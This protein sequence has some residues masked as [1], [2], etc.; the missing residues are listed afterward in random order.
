MVQNMF[1]FIVYVNESIIQGENGAYFHSDAPLMFRN[2]RISTLYELKQVILSHH[3][4]NGPRE[5]RRLAYRFQ[6]VTPDDRLEYRPSWLS[7]DRHVWITF[8][9]HRRIMQDRFME[10]L[11]EVCHVDGPSGFCPYQ[12]PADPAPINIVSPDYNSHK[13]S[14][15]DDESSGDSTDEDELVLNI[16]AAGDPRLMLPAPKPI[17]ALMDVPSFFQQLDID[18]RHVDDPTMESVAVEYNTDGGVEFV[19]GHAQ[20]KGSADSSEEL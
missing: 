19:V 16:P 10:F 8:E 5:I 1:H 3:G 17:P 14:D 2:A 4:K 20:S 11:A 18:V 12:L 13:D 9:V 6:A 15:Y 7:E